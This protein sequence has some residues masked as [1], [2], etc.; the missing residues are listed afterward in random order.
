MGPEYGIPMDRQVSRFHTYEL[1]PST[2]G[3]LHVDWPRAIERPL[4]YVG[5]YAAGAL[6]AS[7]KLFRAL[8]VTVVR[9]T[10]RFRD[11][12]PQGE[13][14]AAD[15]AGG[16]LEQYFK[17]NAQQIVNSSLAGFFAAL[18][19]ATVTFPVCSSSR[20]TFIGLFYYTF[21][22]GYLTTGR[23]LR[24]ME[25]NS[26]SPIFSHFG[27]LLLGIVTVRA[28]SAEKL[29]LDNL[30]TRIDL[31]SVSVL[32]SITN[33]GTRPRKYGTHSGFWLLLNFDF[34]GS[35]LSNPGMWH[36]IFG[37][38]SAISPTSRGAVANNLM[39]VSRLFKIKPPRKANSDLVKVIPE[40]QVVSPS[41]GADIPDPSPSRSQIDDARNKRI[42]AV[43]SDSDG[44]DTQEEGSVF[45]LK[46]KPVGCALD[47]PTYSTSLLCSEISPLRRRRQRLAPDN[48]S[49]RG[50]PLR[51]TSIHKHAHNPAGLDEKDAVYADTDK[52]SCGLPR[53]QQHCRR[54]PVGFCYSFACGSAR[55][56]PSAS[57]S[58]SP[59]P[60]DL[61]FKLCRLPLG[62]TGLDELHLRV[63]SASSAD[64]NEQRNA[65]KDRRRLR[66]RRALH[67]RDWHHS[68]RALTSRDVHGVRPSLTFLSYHLPLSFRSQMRAS[69]GGLAD[70]LCKS[71]LA[72]F[73][74]LVFSRVWQNSRFATWHLESTQNDYSPIASAGRSGDTGRQ[75][76]VN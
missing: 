44:R 8:L 55:Q 33:S 5:I 28:F 69:L 52:V 74:H 70:H 48:R 10:F 3:F 13:F 32:W 2:T 47:N 66:R 22:I 54:N 29:F 20:A 16:F 59:V 73:S 15:A 34:L 17:E 57:A 30:H 36:Q 71:V 42:L 51:I 9:A 1:H 53:L 14:Y 39:A 23:H 46:W 68:D 41:N 45:V 67:H 76:W 56:L 50:K 24:R 38:D 6:R 43:V 31:V 58:T 61:G 21:A 40:V 65:K 37:L 35:L 62:L 12:T 18:L 19:T 72:V 27:E 63:L 75:H 60:S 64:Q 4:F 11:T 49:G 7:R 25:S 26:R